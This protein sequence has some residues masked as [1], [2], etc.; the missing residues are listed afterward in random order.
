MHMLLSKRATKF[1]KGLTE[2]FCYDIIIFN[3]IIWYF[4]MLFDFYI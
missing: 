1:K 4:L 3:K 2:Y